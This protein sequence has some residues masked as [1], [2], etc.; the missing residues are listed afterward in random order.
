MIHLYVKTHNITGLKY[1]GK[2]TQDPHKY[3]GSGKY[4]KLHIQKHGYNVSTEIIGSYTDLSECYAAALAFSKE[5]DIVRSEQWANLIEEN[6]LDGAPIGHPGHMFTEQ[7]RV[8]LSQSLKHR[9]GDADYKARLSAVH[10][11]R[12]TA[13]RKA[14]Q[15]VRLREQHWTLDR[16]ADHAAKMRARP[17]NSQFVEYATQPKSDAHKKAISAALSGKRKSDDHKQ[18][19]KSPKP[20]VVC[21]IQDRKLMALGN[22]MNWA[23]RFSPAAKDTDS[24]S[25]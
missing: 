20:L 21:R 9:W 3:R 14:Q 6:G 22:F 17:A 12:W 4:W 24:I 25:P 23:K 7:E 2:T 1:F 13:A 11:Q 15:S 16:R 5:H 19:L 8:E 10:K 18:K